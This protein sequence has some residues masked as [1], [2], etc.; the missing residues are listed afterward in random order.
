MVLS[1]SKNLIPVVVVAGMKWDRER[2][3]EKE[4]NITCIAFSLYGIGQIR[5]SFNE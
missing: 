1:T 5:F 3:T 2:D 4:E